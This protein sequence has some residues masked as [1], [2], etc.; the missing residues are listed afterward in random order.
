MGKLDPIVVSIVGSVIAVVAI[1]IGVSWASNNANSY[2][3]DTATKCIQ[4]GAQ[5][6]PMGPSAYNGFCIKAGDK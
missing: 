1:I 4:S 2:Y 3:Y 6:L 5:W